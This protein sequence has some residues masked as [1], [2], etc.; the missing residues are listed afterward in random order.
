MGALFLHELFT[1]LPLPARA[2]HDVAVQLTIPM[3]EV[4]SLEKRTTAFV[5][6]N[7]IQLS[8]RTAKYTFTSFLARDTTYDVLFNVWRL[9]RPEDSTMGSYGPSPRGSL[10]ND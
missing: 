10:E 8:T 9:A 6:P 4:S 5:I 3:Y 7:A 2:H 1:D